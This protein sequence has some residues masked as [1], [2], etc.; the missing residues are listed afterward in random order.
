VILTA[1]DTNDSERIA[2][3]KEAAL[4]KQQNALPSWHT[5]STVTGDLTSFGL[6]NLSDGAEGSSSLASQNARLLEDH[7][8]RKNSIEMYYARLE[9]EDRASAAQS[10]MDVDQTSRGD[11]SASSSVRNSTLAPLDAAINRTYSASSLKRKLAESTA[12]EAASGSRLK[13]SRSASYQSTPPSQTLTPSR[14][15]S[16]DSNGSSQSSDTGNWHRPADGIPESQ[17]QDSSSVTVNGNN[18][19]KGPVLKPSDPVVYVAG[20]P[21]PLSEITDEHHE[22]MTPDEYERYA[23]VLVAGA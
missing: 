2:R 4:R 13:H 20:A 22:L 5:R 9:A 7:E 6:Q 11:L 19:S 18:V 3:E 15:K 1:D 12:D 17:R 21:V 16:R 14:G 8:E 10:P 23:H